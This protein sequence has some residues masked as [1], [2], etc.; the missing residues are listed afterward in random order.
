[1]RLRT[2]LDSTVPT[3]ALSLSR[4][5]NSLPKSALRKMSEHNLTGADLL[6][7]TDECV[8]TPLP[9]R[10]DQ[11]PAQ[12]ATIVDRTTFCAGISAQNVK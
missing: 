7:V 5:L 8:C 1:M 6:G 12:N 9:I 10:V 3:N 4:F 2:L 11:S